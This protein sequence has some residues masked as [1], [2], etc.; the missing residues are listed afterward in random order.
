MSSVLH[1]TRVSSV[2]STG[3]GSSRVISRP[4]STVHQALLLALSDECMS[5]LFHYDLC[6]V[7]C[8]GVWWKC[9]SANTSAVV[10]STFSSSVQSV[11]LEM[12]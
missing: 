3:T 6:S 9:F 4:S 11:K 7:H 8:T 10:V 2:A 1:L 5:T 12:R